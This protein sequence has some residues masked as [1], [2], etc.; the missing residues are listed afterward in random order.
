MT[1]RQTE[2]ILQLKHMDTETFII[3][4]HTDHNNK[5]NINRTI[6]TLVICV[7]QSRRT[8]VIVISNSYHKPKELNYEIAL[9]L[10]PI[11]V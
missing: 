2:A 5:N 8:A 6:K 9:T 3:T 10:K 11:E 4:E 1:C 7:G